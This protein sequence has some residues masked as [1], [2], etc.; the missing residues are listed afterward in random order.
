METEAIYRDRVWNVEAQEA[1]DEQ[2]ALLWLLFWVV[3]LQKEK[4]QGCHNPL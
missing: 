1:P 2:R 4:A 3:F